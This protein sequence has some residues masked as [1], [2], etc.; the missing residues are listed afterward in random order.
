MT[1]SDHPRR[2]CVYFNFGKRYALHLVV[3]VHSLRRHYDG[4]VTVFLLDE[5]HTT[6]LKR[7][8]EKLGAS[9]VVTDRLSKSGDRHLV[10]RESPYE[11]TLLFDSDIIFRAP[12]DDLWEPLER[13]GALVTRFATP[14]SGRLKMLEGVA[15]LVGRERYERAVIR[16]RDER[17]DINVGVMGFARPR[18]D[19][20]LA[21]WSDCMEQGRGKD[22][23]LLDEMSVV[24]LAEHHPHYLADEQWNCPADEM[25]RSIDPAEA[26]ILHFFLDGAVI[27]GRRIGRNVETWTGRQWFEAYRAAKADIDLSR[28]RLG[29]AYFPRNAER[30]FESGVKV[31]LRLWLKDCERA[32]RRIRNGIFRTERKEA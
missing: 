25:F 28:W 23:L 1:N 12:I 18:G 14:P 2:G 5:P 10:F 16:V 24:A 9:V 13:E 4:P 20:F 7:D 17:V 11:T 22:I 31:T 26:K 27:D 19:A 30:P 8:L 32:I 29:D 6:A 21:E 3:S 15:P